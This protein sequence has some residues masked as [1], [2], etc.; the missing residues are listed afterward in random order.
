MKL[1]G[2]AV[3]MVITSSL[4]V[5]QP[6]GVNAGTGVPPQDV[7]VTTQ[8]SDTTTEVTPTG[9]DAGQGTDTNPTSELV[10]TPVVLTPGRIADEP[11][12]VKI[13]GGEPRAVDRQGHV[14]PKPHRAH[15]SGS[16]IPKT[17]WDYRNGRTKHQKVQWNAIST[18]QATANRAD[19]KADNLNT[20]VKRLE[21]K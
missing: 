6:T 20:R 3:L 8:S 12:Y 11:L 14:Q 13:I 7:V 2:I 16:G 17:L 4:V 10:P 21:G 19:A 5:A 9:V 1:I 18:A 15:R